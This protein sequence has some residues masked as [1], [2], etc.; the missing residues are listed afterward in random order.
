MKQGRS[1]LILLAGIVVLGA[2]IWIQGAWRARAVPAKSGSG[3]LFDLNPETLAT[4][5]FDSTT[6]TV[7][8]LKQ[9]GVWMT[10]SSSNG[11][12]RADVA[13]V[14]RMLSGL[15]SLNT[16]ATITAKQLEMRGLNV[17][18]YGF[19]QPAL[20]ISAVDNKGAH[21]WLVGRKTPLGDMLYIK[22]DGEADIYTAS[23][24][25]LAMTPTQPG[26]LRDRTLFS[27]EVTGVRRV[28]IR[29]PGGFVQILKDPKSGW[30][31]QQPIAALADP[32]QVEALLGKLYQLRVEDFIAD[33][34]SDFAVYG[35][36]GETR[37]ISLGGVDGTSRM[38]VL[39]DA[40]VDR[41][42]LVYARRADDT[43]VFALKA[44]VLNLLKGKPDDFRDVR[45]LPLSA[46]E[47]S[48]VSIEHGTEQLELVR[49]EAG[50]WKISKP[51]S[52]EADPQAVANLLLM[53]S[54][55][56]IVEFGD[57]SPPALAEWK[58]V[59]AAD[60]TGKTNRI[61]VLPTLGKQDGLRIRRDGGNAVYQINLPSVPASVIDPLYY[62]DR[63]VWELKREDV[64]K[65]SVDRP[66]HPRQVVERQADGS[67]APA[68]TNGAVR[69]V[70]GAVAKLLNGLATVSTSSYVAYNPR[71][72]S[73]Y[74]LAD[75]SVALY[76]GLVGSD[77]LG[78]VLLVGREAAEG[79]YAMVKGRD[80]VFMLNKTLVE[81]LSAD[82]VTGQDVVV[83]GTE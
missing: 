12:G 57:T 30:Q 4:I 27:G 25:L 56:V 19:G 21:A 9:N 2:F 11:I 71:D 23:A 47:I 81:L 14:H 32:N 42:G 64:Q 75:P 60:G 51:V 77:Q 13:L 43:S 24:K 54:G 55:A 1:T 20:R 33:N 46:K 36:Q 58:L 34:V 70:E 15:N 65:I 18:E 53:W 66:A 67:F 3:R 49:G 37:Q 74:G 29:G 63:L 38:L 80:V 40:I 7:V 35:L 69:V 17:D 16:M 45:V 76:I 62:K 79:F 28:E 78:R 50:T 59:F 31:I 72:L 82:L 6:N 10:G 83:T 52:W 22:R 48:Y 8:C 41:A 61:D 68:E 39:G 73:I 26:Q 5:R 44:E